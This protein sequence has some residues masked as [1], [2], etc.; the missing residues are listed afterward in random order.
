M[1]ESGPLIN[2]DLKPLADVAIKLLDKLDV[3]F[4]FSVP[5]GKRKDR[6]MATE[7]F[8]KGIQDDQSLSLLEKAAFTSNA[9]KIIKEYINHLDILSFALDKMPNDAHPEDLDDE[10]VSRFMESSKHVSDKQMQMIWGKLLAQECGAPGQTPKSLINILSSMDRSQAETFVK[11]NACTMTLMGDDGESESTIIY[12]FDSRQEINF[13]VS[14]EDLNELDSL[15]LLTFEPL[16]G[17]LFTTFHPTSASYYA[18]SV[19]LECYDAEGFPSGNVLMT[20]AGLCLSKAIISEKVQDY[21]EAICSFWEDN[22]VKLI[23]IL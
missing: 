17:Y 19:N 21:F 10:W 6:E 23:D 13:G 15:G 7:A 12:P 1:S 18:Q 11:L 14:F 22:K 3:C 9:R 5:K 2:V 4:G 16:G 8:I 20:K